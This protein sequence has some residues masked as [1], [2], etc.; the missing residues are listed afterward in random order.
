MAITDDQVAALRAQLEGRYDEHRQI[1]QRLDRA[2]DNVAYNALVSAAF[3]EASRD[4]FLRD[5]VAA[6]DAEVIEFI[7]YT[8]ERVPDV[9]DDIDPDIA[10]RLILFVIGKLPLDANDDIKGNVALAT[11][12]LLLAALIHDANPSQAEFEAFMA[13]VRRM[14]EKA[15]Q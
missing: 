12:V 11:K 9:A 3:F 14:A 1:L 10:E 6:E 13:K 5:G 7:A 8:R 4:R 2:E 15:V